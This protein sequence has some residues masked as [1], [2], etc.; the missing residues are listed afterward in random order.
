LSEE[1]YFFTVVSTGAAVESIGTTAVVSTL[2]SVTVVAVES[3]VAVS[4]FF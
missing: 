4:A 2:V 3:V 1:N